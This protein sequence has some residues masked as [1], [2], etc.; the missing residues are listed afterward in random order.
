MSNVSPIRAGVTISDQSLPGAVGTRVHD[1]YI[2]QCLRLRELQLKERTDDLL[3][4]CLEIIGLSDDPLLAS[5]ART[6][7]EKYRLA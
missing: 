2:A 5:K 3:A 4:L 1:Q 6:L 7:I